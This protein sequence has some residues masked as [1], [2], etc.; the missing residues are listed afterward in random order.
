M[1]NSICFLSVLLFCCS[2]FPIF[3]QVVIN[4][5][6]NANVKNLMDEANEY[7]DWIE[8][9]NAS[10]VPVSL[11]GYFLSDNAKKPLKW[12][13]PNI[14]IS[15]KS[16]LVVF[17][18]GKDTVIGDFIHTNFKI[19]SEGEEIILS[20]DQQLVI[21]Q[22]NPGL[23][24]PGHSRGRK[25]DGSATWFLFD[26]PSPKASNNNLTG[27]LGY[28]PTPAFSVKA[29]FF[30]SAQTVELSTTSATGIIKYTLDGRFPTGSATVYSAPILAT[31]TMVISAK[32]F[33]NG[34]LLPSFTAKQTYFIN[35]SDIDL[36]VISLTMDPKDLW[37]DSDGIYTNFMSRDEKTCHFEYFDK[38]KVKQAE[39]TAGV[40]I[41]GNSSR[42][43]DQKS[44]R[45]FCRK[46][47][48]ASSIEFPFFTE[49]P[50]V[51]SF[52]RLTIRGAGSDFNYTRMRDPY[53]QRLLKDSPVDRMEFEPVVV[54]LNGEYWG[55]YNLREHHSKHYL[56]TYYGISKNNIDLLFHRGTTIRAEDGDT[57]EFF[58][59]YKYIMSADHNDPGFYK[60]VDK[61]LDLESFTD[62][63]AAEIFYYNEDWIDHTASA[64]N[65][66]FWRERSPEGKFR[67]MLWDLDYGCGLK[68]RFLPDF[69][70]LEMVIN[71]N[72][73]NV[74]SDMFRKLL[75]N[76]EFHRYYVN[77][78]AD[79]INT[80]F[81]YE[82][83]AKVA[84]SIRDSMASSIP[85]HREK[86]PTSIDWNRSIDKMLE[87]AEAR[88]NPARK[89]IN[90]EF[91][92]NGEV[93]ISLDVVPAGAGKIKIN[94]IT[95]ETLPWKGIYFDGVPVTLT[96][97]P[98][99]GFT[100]EFWAENQIL[101]KE[102]AKSI[103]IDVEFA[104]DAFIAHFIAT[105]ADP[106]LIFT[107][108]NY[109]SDPKTDSGDWLELHN[110]G[111]VS[112][113]LKGWSLKGNGDIKVFEIP[114]DIFIKPGGYIVF[115]CDTQKFSAQYPEVQNHIG[116][117]P[118]SFM[119][120]GDIIQLFD[121]KNELYLMVRFKSFDP[122]PKEASG[123]GRTLEL[124]NYQNE[125][126]SP[127]NWF[128]GCI[129]GSPG[130]GFQDNCE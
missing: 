97:I 121:F 20:N 64:N 127:S 68:L 33:S 38:Q 56:E 120:S 8:F 113:N 35:D 16:F 119:S 129:G 27:Y 41:Q 66:R 126:D 130:I 92:L 14:Q 19:S 25:P 96:V 103:T 81:T 110:Y 62:Y 10:N 86:W 72:E 83:M 84:Y 100:F 112:I 74:H 73:D 90:D 99:P 9:Y 69:N 111:N 128:A 32:A 53:M 50:G 44:F 79:L 51:K 107:E 115:V 125:Q 7:E 70:S 17:A 2:T 30:P 117:L 22:V 6:S 29:G 71:P 78:Y 67:Y 24:Q 13:F 3:G 28:E 95:P 93:E 101:K 124:K 26:N 23:L 1:K 108:I 18:S 114:D 89:H 123:T 60:S 47:Y 59:M 61:K 80:V 105:P 91:K 65:I 88:M 116:Q 122:W 4:E 54:F 11:N 42:S 48:G 39:I 43:R 36:P 76:K 31:K 94:T 49:R 5:I 85:R 106:K 58:E 102:F 118:F 109:H 15:A 21:G 34:N 77:R 37:D 87:W 52:S 55:H 45:I 63:M 46:E 12:A 57:K 104:N 82:N 75:Q 98:N 40:R